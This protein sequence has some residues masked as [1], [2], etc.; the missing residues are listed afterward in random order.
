MK[1][2]KTLVP[3]SQDHHNG[4]MLAQLI[5]KDAPQYKGLPT[6]IEGK[7]IYTKDIWENELK[8]HFLNEE[9]ILFPAVRGKNEEIDNL[10]SELIAE[11]KTI[12][13]KINDLRVNDNII[14]DLNNLGMILEKHIRKEERILFQ[15]LQHYCLNELKE[16]EGRITPANKS[17]SI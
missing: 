14:T 16:I 8:T 2:H 9:Q 15:K 7:I 3:L 12:K 11:H 17:C 4:L 1:R 5:K 6:N 13:V 10:I